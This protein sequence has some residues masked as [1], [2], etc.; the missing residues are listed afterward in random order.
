MNEYCKD[1][2]C[3]GDKYWA[4]HSWGIWLNYDCYRY[5]K[6]KNAGCDC[7]QKEEGD[8]KF[9]GNRA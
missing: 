8:Y 1:C 3:G 9:D 7:S 6:C 2:L 5:R 4:K